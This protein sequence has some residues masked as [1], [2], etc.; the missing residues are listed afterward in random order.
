MA[1][2]RYDEDITG[3][4]YR[5]T[6]LERANGDVLERYWARGEPLWPSMRKIPL[7]LACKP[8]SIF[9]NIICPQNFTLRKVV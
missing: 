1:R 3:F 6:L 9:I 5:V 8:L 4:R 7:E 2:S